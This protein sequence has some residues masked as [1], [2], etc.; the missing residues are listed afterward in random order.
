MAEHQWATKLADAVLADLSIGRGELDKLQTMP[1]QQL[2]AAIPPALQK[3]T[4]AAR[5]LLD[6]YAFGPVVEGHDLPRH[7]FDPDAT[8]V[9]ADVPVMVGGTRDENSIFLA[10]DDAVWN[11]SLSESELKQRVAKIAG[12]D[13]DAVIALYRGMH[14]EMNPAELLIEITTDS[15]FWVRSVL[16]AERKAA[17]GTAPVFMYSFNWQTPVLG[18]RLMSPHAL[19]VPFVFDTTDQTGIADHSAQARAIAAVESATWAAFARSGRPDNKAIPPWPAY[20]PEERATM[21]IDTEWRVDNDPQREA[22]LLWSRI[23][24]A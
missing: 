11:R 18:G 7:P 16:L 5:P 3:V 24:Q 13:T 21:M 6:R 4:P 23:A 8:P 2:I 20:R 22:R 9:S 12:G 1:F 15:N 19:D 10:P 14:P 17:Q